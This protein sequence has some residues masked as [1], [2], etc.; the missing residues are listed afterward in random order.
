[1]YAPPHRALDEGQFRPIFF[2]FRIKFKG[3]CFDKLE[4]FRQD[5]GKNSHP[6]SR[7]LKK[8]GHWRQTPA[9]NNKNHAFWKKWSFYDKIASL[10]HQMALFIRRHVV[11]IILVKKIH[12][13]VQKVQNLWFSVKAYGQKFQFL[14]VFAGLLAITRRYRDSVAIHSWYYMFCLRKKGANSGRSPKNAIF[15]QSKLLIR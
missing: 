13:S 9:K 12:P 1:M 2:F 6:E 15:S 8:N 7:I 14:P 4:V 11:L 10:V 5:L 3:V